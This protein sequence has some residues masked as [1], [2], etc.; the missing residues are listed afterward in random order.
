MYMHIFIQFNIQRI[1]LP[2]SNHAIVVLRV[3]LAQLTL[4]YLPF[5]L[6]IQFN[7]QGYAFRSISPSNHTIVVLS[8]ACATL[9]EAT[10]PVKLPSKQP[11]CW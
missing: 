5:R 3:L 8:H 9:K 11:L 1:Y 10:A 7:F 6:F 2:P 4:T